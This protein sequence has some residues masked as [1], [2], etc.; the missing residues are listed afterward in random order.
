MA[1][2]PA[3]REF[4]TTPRSTPRLVG[5]RCYVCRKKI[6]HHANALCIGYHEGEP[7]GRHIKCEPGS[8]AWL[9]AME[10]RGLAKTSPTYK[11][12]KRAEKLRKAEKTKRREER[13]M[14]KKVSKEKVTKAAEV[15]SPKASKKTDKAPE[16]GGHLIPKEAV[17]V[18]KK[19]FKHPQIGKL[20]KELVEVD[21]SSSEAAKLRKQLRDFGFKLS[22]ESTWTPFLEGEEVEVPEKA[23]KKK[24]K[25]GKKAKEEKASKKEKTKGKKKIE[26]E[27]EEDEEEEDEEE[28]EE[29]EEDED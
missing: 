15:E 29:E 20:V 19:L 28:D 16:K 24:D 18:P 23:G 10:K 26:P 25:K 1:E 13:Q 27:E 11:F 6:K 12:F 4:P 22:D 14:A 2:L 21:R 17:K 9:R 8:P 3:S 7:L 5:R